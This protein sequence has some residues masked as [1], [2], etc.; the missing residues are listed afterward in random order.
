M[1]KTKKGNQWYSGMKSHIGVDA[2]SGL[3]HKLVAT[4]ANVSHITQAHAL[5]HGD[6]T[7]AWGD[8][9]Y[10]GVDKRQKNQRSA[11]MWLVALHPG[12][13]RALPE[14]RIVLGRE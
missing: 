14:T 6:V 13:R 3:T 2:D 4:A 9:D 8:A 10:Q 12:K 1:H 7:T 11:V 5:L